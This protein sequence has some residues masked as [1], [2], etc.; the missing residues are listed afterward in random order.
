MEPQTWNRLLDHVRMLVQQ[1]KW[2]RPGS[3]II[4]AVSGGPD[5]IALLHVLHQL[6]P[7]YGWSVICAHMNH[8]FRPEESAAEARFVEAEA[9][10]LSIP[11]ESEQVD[12]PA[13]MQQTG[14]GAQE[15]AR[16]LRYRFLHNIAAKHSADSIALAHHMDDQAETVMM[17]IIRGTGPDGIGGIKMH[18]IE[19]NVELVRPFLRIYKAD[20]IRSCEECHFRYM[21]D[22]S[23]E[24]RKYTRNRIR[25]DVLPFLEQY[26]KQLVPT[27]ARLAEIAGPESEYIQQQTEAL[28]AELVKE[29]EG[30]FSFSVT[31][32]V[33]A[34]VALQRRLIKLIL[35]YLSSTAEQFDFAK[36]EL[37][38]QQIV[39]SHLTSWNL[40]IGDRIICV[41][42]YE[43]IRFMQ[44][45]RGEPEPFCI[46]LQRENA[47]I[48]IPGSL[49]QMEIR[50][51][52]WKEYDSE[53]LQ[54]SSDEALFDAD[55]TDFPLYLRSR[56]PGDTIRLLGSG[57]KKVKNL[58][59][60]AKIPLSQRDSLPLL[61]DHHGRILWIP[62]VRR[63]QE[64][65]LHPGSVHC[66]YMRRI[67][68]AK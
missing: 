14:K 23:N 66:L 22:S 38:R 15:A 43:D 65:L 53:A 10:A 36:I 60:D 26:N 40:D 30:S 62:G 17:R 4:A 18:R 58:F 67:K 2:W 57:T 64:A 16:E 24:L 25:L 19:K 29:K 46:P 68:S 44:D 34:H 7:E 61:T 3:C 35:N 32:F 20:L 39:H 21:N 42:E 48:S 41:R 33:G 6:S 31:S 28:Y 52:E 5:S 55:L 8:G 27:L 12:A 59:I 1:E 11:F 56:R 54:L 45:Y 49:D 13:Y 9:S 47:V 51:L 37:I 63:S 50:L